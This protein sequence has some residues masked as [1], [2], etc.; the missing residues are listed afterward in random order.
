MALIASYVLLLG[1]KTTFHRDIKLG[2]H[3][4]RLTYRWQRVSLD[5]AYMLN[6]MVGMDVPPDRTGWI[7]EDTRFIRPAKL[8][9]GASSSGIHHDMMEVQIRELLAPF[10]NPTWFRPL[11]PTANGEYRFYFMGGGGV[12]HYTGVLTFGGN[13]ARVSYDMAGVIRTASVGS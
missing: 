2:P 6:G 7:L 12:G 8:S 1:A 5:Y 9:T 13:V 4:L 10:A 11:P 3:T